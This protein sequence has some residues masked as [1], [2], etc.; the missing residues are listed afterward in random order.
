MFKKVA[1][2]FSGHALS[3]MLLF[4]RNILM[5]RLVGVEDY[6]IAALFAMAMAVIEMGTDIGLQQFI[7][8][9]DDGDDPEFQ[10]NLQGFHLLR[11]VCAALVVVACAHPFAAFMGVAEVAWAFQVLAVT[12]LALGL[13]HFDIYR[14]QRKLR[15]TPLLL[16]QGLSCFIGLAVVY[17]LALGF[18]DYRVMLYSLI[19]QTVTLALV[20]H[21]LSERAYR[22]QLEREMIRRM[23]VF[24]WPLLVNG[25]LMFFVLNGEKMAVGRELST[26]ALG[27]F[28]MGMTLTV[29]PGLILDRTIGNFFLPQVSAAKND[30][31]A[32]RR[33]A[34]V[35]VQTSFLSGLLLVAGVA[36]LG[37]WFVTLALGL[38]FAPLTELLVWLVILQAIRSGKGGL[39]AAS[40]A[41]GKTSNMLYA[42]LCRVLSLPASWYALIQGAELWMVALI[43][44]GGEFCGFLVSQALLRA[45]L[46]ILL[47][48]LLPCYAAMGLFYACLIFHVVSVQLLTAP[49]L[50][51]SVTLGAT[52]AAFGLALSSLRD[53]WRYVGQRNYSAY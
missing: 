5:A 19:A 10:A 31:E 4:A 26:A 27:V 38:D 14:L 34:Y 7:V 47:R 21:L 18:G 45:Q 15:Y 42:N 20:S 49:P 12:R 29:T 8:Q 36:T 17:P 37:P 50:P 40:M 35:G 9:A 28:A 52:V 33:I 44:T 6:G 53:L 2:L 30:P 24:G 22:L 23:L 32:F 1:L 3:A 39:V 25:L 13:V 11:A 43:A 46:R 41:K 16:S 48:P 51:A